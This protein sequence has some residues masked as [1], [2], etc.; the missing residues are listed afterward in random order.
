MINMKKILFTTAV[1]ALMFTSCNHEPDFEGLQKYHPGNM[2]KLQLSYGGTYTG[3]NGFNMGEDDPEDPNAVAKTKIEDW[4]NTNY[5]SAENGSEATIKYNLIKKETTVSEVSSIAVDFE[6][7]I[8]T[9]EKTNIPGWTNFEEVGTTPWYDSNYSGNTYTQFGNG[10]TDV[11]NW[12]ISPKTLI[13]GG[14]K[15]S[16]DVCVGYWKGD[17]LS[18]LISEN[19]VGAASASN[20]KKATWVDV[21]SSFTIP[22]EP[23]KGYGK[24][25]TAGSLDLSAYADKDVYI[26]FKYVGSASVNTTIELDNIKV[27]HEQ[28][29][30]NISTVEK[31]A[32]AIVDNNE[33]KW[34]VTL[35]SDIP[36]ILVDENFESGK[37]YDNFAGEGWLN[38]LLQ[39][40]Y[41]W[42]YKSY[43][44]NLYVSLSANKHDGVL[45]NWLV[46]PKLKLVKD[47]VL[48]FDMELGYYNGDA[49]SLMISD[50]FNGEPS[51]IATSTWT[52]L[53]SN[54]DIDKSSTGG[55]DSSWSHYQV[56]LSAY[57][58]KTVYIAFKYLGNGTKGDN[59]LSTTYQL[60]NIY[61]GIPK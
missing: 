9:L 5:Y 37:A 51:S 13:K 8:V 45:E 6:R 30:V 42:Q 33:S 31:Q 26:A 59:L 47:M 11:T 4:L 25:A 41:Y 35:P 23:V 52:D 21:T 19:Y 44:G 36:D 48:K 54:L 56:D 40:T 32:R 27:S 46:T 57:V 10:S 60:D 16:F 18:V 34:T 55:Y 3:A 39:G 43:G 7:N 24:F 20:L 2:A 61:I 1:L 17:V 22:Q 14:D 50:D 49:F 53:T 28:S 38:A 15:L 58:G 29:T 12:F